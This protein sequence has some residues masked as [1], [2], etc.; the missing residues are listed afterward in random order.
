[1]LPIQNFVHGQGYKCG[2][3]TRS[4]P[5]ACC[6]D[7]KLDLDK[8]TAGVWKQVTNTVA[9]L[10]MYE[11]EAAEAKAGIHRLDEAQR[12]R[13]VE[14]TLGEQN[15]PV[16]FTIKAGQ[17]EVTEGQLLPS[18]E[19]AV[20]LNRAIVHALNE[21]IVEGATS[22]LGTQR[23]YNT[24]RQKIHFTNWSIQLDDLA[25]RHKQ[26]HIKELQLFHVN[27]AACQYL[28]CG[29]IAKVTA[30]DKQMELLLEHSTLMHVR[31][32]PCTFY[33][34]H[35]LPCV[36][37]HAST[38]EVQVLYHSA[39]RLMFHAGGTGTQQKQG[40]HQRDR[41]RGQ[42]DRGQ[43]KALD[44]H[45]GGAEYHGRQATPHRRCHRPRRHT[46]A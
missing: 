28:E 25:R 14:T 42:W 33:R 24:A 1:M 20:M 18:F 27:R 12:I 31:L 21:S 6:R 41:S 29:S 46:K 7:C 32:L 38:W 4:H 43:R 30:M 3:E 9:L 35:G 44:L 23:S 17:M 8:Q 2:H 22:V 34:L 13:E 5:G 19:D 37:L 40:L 10:D 26:E 39:H 16:T 36:A 11:S 45:R 15:V